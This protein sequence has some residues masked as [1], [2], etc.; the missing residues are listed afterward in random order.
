VSATIICVM[1]VAGAGKTTIGQLL[2]TELHC[3]FLDADTLHPAANI[4]KMT[5]G[6]PL[7]DADRAPWLALFTHALF[8]HFIVTKTWSLPA[9]PS[10]SDTGTL[11]LMEFRWSG[12]I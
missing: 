6:I 7:T 12:C 1:G 4:Q 3:A 11:S 9:R 10:N 5:Q 2:A 8:I